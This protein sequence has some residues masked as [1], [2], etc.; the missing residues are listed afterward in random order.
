M[1]AT[2]AARTLQQRRVIARADDHHAALQPFVAEAV[3]DK[4]QHLAA[5]LANQRDHRNVGAG[6]SWR[7][8]DI[9][10]LLPTPGPEKM[11]MRWPR[12]QVCRPS[13]ARMLVAM[14]W[15]MFSRCS[16]AHAAAVDPPR[17]A[18]QQ[19]AFAVDR[20]A[21]AIEHAAEQ[22][23]RAPDARRG[24]DVFDPIAARHAARAPTAA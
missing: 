4:F 6:V 18:Q 7:S 13:I 5:A 22:L 23:L 14:G 8:T 20:L 1:H 12:P 15:R 21:K 3:F 24:R 19:R 2:F 16:G 9:S 11:P 10:V 17:F